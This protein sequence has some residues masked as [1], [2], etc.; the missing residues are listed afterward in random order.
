MK[1]TPNTTKGQSTPPQ[2]LGCP[3]CGLTDYLVSVESPLHYYEVS[4]DAAGTPTYGQ[5]LK[6]F[7]GEM[8]GFLCTR[9]GCDFAELP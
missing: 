6:E 7:E 1:A 2:G 3:D 9:C 4:F 5:L 8:H